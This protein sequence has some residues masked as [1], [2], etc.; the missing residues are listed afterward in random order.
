MYLLFSIFFSELGVTVIFRILRLLFILWILPE[1]ILSHNWLT[2]EV[3]IHLSICFPESFVSGKDE[4][5]FSFS[6]T[7]RL[8]ITILDTSNL[9]DF[10]RSL[11]SD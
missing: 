1:E 7:S 3:R 5:T 6:F 10:L 8:G 9:E 11:T 2:P 4:V